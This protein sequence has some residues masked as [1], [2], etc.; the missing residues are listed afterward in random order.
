MVSVRIWRK[1]RLLCTL[2]VALH[3]TA[4]FIG[5]QNIDLCSTPVLGQ[6]V[7]FEQVACP[8]WDAH[9]EPH[10]KELARPLALQWQAKEQDLKYHVESFSQRLTSSGKKHVLPCIRRWTH[11]ACIKSHLYYNVYVLPHVKHVRYKCQLW[12]QSDGNVAK[13]TLSTLDHMSSA[14]SKAKALAHRIGNDL[15]PH[16]SNATKYAKGLISQMAD[17]ASEG[18]AYMQREVTKYMHK[19]DEGSQAAEES[20]YYDAENGEEQVGKDDEEEYDEDEDEEEETLYLT[21]TIVETVTLS[22]NQLAAPT[23]DS[24]ADAALEVPLRDLVQDEFQAWSNTVKQKALNTEGQ[25]DVEIEALKRDKLDVFRPRITALLQDISNSTQQHYRIINKAILDVNCTME[26]HPETGEQIYFNREGTQLRKYVT[27]PLM[28][29]FFS[30][31]HT[32]VDVALEEV[33]ALLESFIEEVNAEVDQLRQEHLEVYEEWGDV[34]VSEWSKRMAYVDVVAAMDS[35]DLG[36]RQHDN[37]KQFLKLKKQVIATRDVLMKH[38]ANLLDV[39]KFLKEIQFTLKALQREAGEYL[40]ILRSKANLAFQAREELERKE[41]VEQV[42]KEKK[43]QEERERQEQ[44]E[45]LRQEQLEEEKFQDMY[46]SLEGV[47]D[48]SDEKDQSEAQLLQHEQLQR[49][50]LDQEEFE[51]RQQMARE[52]SRDEERYSSQN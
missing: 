33:R 26:H 21:S 32:H 12:L 47:S 51:Q 25:F 14:C 20:L 15:N 27:R 4:L 38:P 6:T 3:F 36:Q 5:S 16:I 41:H 29:E 39:E 37:W 19:S 23:S 13:H 43:E 35:E 49:A 10:R 1:L 28:R 8:W 18:R 50:K 2:L 48:E 17:L 46:E 31:A 30:Q 7:W 22:D 45:R 34:M 11:V 44:E 42:E 40:F 52:Q 9:V 24:G